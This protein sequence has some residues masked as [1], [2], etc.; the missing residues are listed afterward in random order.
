MSAIDKCDK[1][2]HK[3]ECLCS[4][5]DVPIVASN[6]LE[7]L[8]AIIMDPIY[9]LDRIVTSCRL[10][11]QS[12]SFQDPIGT[13]KRIFKKIF[14][15]PKTVKSAIEFNKHDLQLLKPH[16]PL[17]GNKEKW[18]HFFSLVTFTCQVHQNMT[19]EKFRKAYLDDLEILSNDMGTLLLVG[20]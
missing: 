5:Y 14:H 2:L 15:V 12:V 1:Y 4:E 16:L 11:V 7:I 20:T 9:I 8:T 18:N 6:D 13:E 19:N 17:K 10:L 3:S